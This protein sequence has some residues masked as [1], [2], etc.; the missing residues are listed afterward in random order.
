[1]FY[2]LLVAYCFL[3]VLNQSNEIISLLPFNV[4]ANC[5]IVSII[6]LFIK[7]FTIIYETRPNLHR[8]VK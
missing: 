4:Y 6:K 2:N 8:M 7:H 1:M 5:H 3:T